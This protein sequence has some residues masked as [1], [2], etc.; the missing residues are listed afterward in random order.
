MG[1][2]VSLAS[3][4]WSIAATSTTGC[5]TQP[6]IHQRFWISTR[7]RRCSGGT[8]HKNVTRCAWAW[9]SFAPWTCSS[10]AKL[11]P[12]HRKKRQKSESCYAMSITHL[13]ANVMLFSSCRVFPSTTACLFVRALFLPQLHRC[14][15]NISS[16]SLQ[17]TSLDAVLQKDLDSCARV[18]SMAYFAGS[19][20]YGET[21]YSLPNILEVRFS[22]FV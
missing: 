2:P 16:L 1:D 20:A 22:V 10:A 3:R 13:V 14:S 4:G 11:S 18:H 6:R 17:Q 7:A 5:S 8:L 12:T 9:I 21:N 15:A 19:N